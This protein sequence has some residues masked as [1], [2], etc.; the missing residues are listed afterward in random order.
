MSSQETE[1]L[2]DLVVRLEQEVAAERLRFEEH[3]QAWRANSAWHGAELREAKTQLG[4][5]NLRIA[6]L[7]EERDG[8][9]RVGSQADG[10]SDPG[11]AGH[12]PG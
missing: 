1:R 5:A 8:L 12:I 3:L 2:R 7:E 10:A 4:I 9:L 6:R 11:K